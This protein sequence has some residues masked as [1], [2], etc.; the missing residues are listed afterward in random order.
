M[1]PMLSSQCLPNS[2][3]RLGDLLVDGASDVPATK[4]RTA[5]LLAL[6]N[7]EREQLRGTTRAMD[8]SAARTGRG[9]ARGSTREATGGRN[10]TW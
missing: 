2:R 6:A 4:T 3:P 7:G 5:Q 10:M 9:P 1:R 8:W